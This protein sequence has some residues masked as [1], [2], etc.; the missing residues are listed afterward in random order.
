LM[1]CDSDID[2]WRRNLSRKRLTKRC[3][4]IVQAV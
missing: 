2:S 3:S 4:E 1:R